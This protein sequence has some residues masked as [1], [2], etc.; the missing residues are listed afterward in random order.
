MISSLLCEILSRR[1]G[2][3]VRTGPV[4]AT[5]LGNALTQGV[6]LGVFSDQAEARASLSA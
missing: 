4:E 1:S 3:R 2:R 5:A 6:A